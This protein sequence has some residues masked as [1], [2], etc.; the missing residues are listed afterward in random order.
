MGF[1]RSHPLRLWFLCQTGK[2][3]IKAPALAK[4]WAN[5][6]EIFRSYL[7]S[8]IVQLFWKIL[9]LV[10]VKTTVLS[11]QVGNIFK[12]CGL[13]I[14]SELYSIFCMANEILAKC[15]FC[16]L[17]LLG[18]QETLVSKFVKMI[19]CIEIRNVISICRIFLAPLVYVRYKN[20]GLV[21]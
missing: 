2:I 20:K 6:V 7:G 17:S 9:P 13:L 11:Q 12:F 5:D 19:W 10:F 3:I 18:F 14:M 1:F 15:K 16:T 8:K 4:R 21:G